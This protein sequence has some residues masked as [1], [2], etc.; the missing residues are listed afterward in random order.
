MNGNVTSVGTNGG[1]SAYGA[2][3]MGGN[4]REVVSLG[5]STNAAWRGGGFSAGLVNL[6]AT[7]AAAVFTANN[8]SE[9]NGFRLAASVPEPGSTLPILTLFGLALSRSRRRKN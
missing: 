5:V 9:F 1:P 3:D 7:G 8:G 4:I 6:S 2:Y